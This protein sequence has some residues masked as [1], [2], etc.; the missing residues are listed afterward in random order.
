MKKAIMFLKISVPAWILS[1]KCILIRG[2]HNFGRWW[3]VNRPE[4]AH[5]L[6]DDCAVMRDRSNRKSWILRERSNDFT[7]GCK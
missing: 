6:C 5:Q 2:G 7:I 1:L 4:V 3:W